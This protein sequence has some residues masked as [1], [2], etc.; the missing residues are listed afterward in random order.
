LLPATVG[1]GAATSGLLALALRQR[2][3]LPLEPLL[4]LGP[5]FAEEAPLGIDLT[6]RFVDGA[7]IQ[8][9]PPLLSLGLVGG[10]RQKDL[11]SRV[12]VLA[13]FAARSVVG[14]NQVAV[15]PLEPLRRGIAMGVR[16]SALVPRHRESP[17]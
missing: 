1:G 17:K 11:V 6:A 15:D 4:R 3:D 5:N 7:G 8:V 9:S 10:S 12:G 13:R 16:R 14:S 2:L